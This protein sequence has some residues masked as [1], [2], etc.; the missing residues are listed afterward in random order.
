LYL[1]GHSSFGLNAKDLLNSILSHFVT[2]KVS[3]K[4]LESEDAMNQKQRERLLTLNEL[5]KSN[6]GINQQDILRAMVQLE[7]E[8][9]VSSENKYVK[10]D[11]WCWEET[12][13]KATLSQV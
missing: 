3:D 1:D 12:L 5:R 11:Q 4:A 9:M 2:L 10:L 6:P 8:E 13:D 7:F